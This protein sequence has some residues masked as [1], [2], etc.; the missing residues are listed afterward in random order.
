ML[1]IKNV[2]TPQGSFTDLT[3]NGTATQSLDAEKKLIVFPAFVDP[4]VQLSSF[5]VK[6]KEQ[7]KSQA[8]AILQA[9][10]S[11]VFDSQGIA[12][13]EA[14]VHKKTVEDAL[15][16]AN[17]PLSIHFFCDG[18]NAAD[19]D[20][21]GKNK[22]SFIG[23]KTTIDLAK[24]PL[25][26]LSPSVL[27][28]LFQIAAQ[29]DLIVVMAL[30]QGKGDAHEQR[31]NALATVRKSVALAEKYSAQLC[32]QHVRTKEELEVIKEAKKR[33]I[34]VFT[35]VAYPHLFMTENDIPPDVLKAS[36]L[37]LPTP[38]DREALWAAI[39]NGSIDMVGSGSQFSTPEDPIFAARMFFPSMIN[40]YRE[41]KLS[42]GALEA[43]TRVNAQNI[44]R[45][46]PNDDVILVDMNVTKPLAPAYMQKGSLLSYWAE[47][48]F[49]GW[50]THVI[51]R[52]E[53]VSTQ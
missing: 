13:D 24:V 50:P 44:F 31:K 27:D 36:R 33:G 53:L 37:F 4:D 47:R 39:A 8:K 38:D 7:W 9:G 52:G 32:L 3:F 6:S 48:T 30:M 28:R 43:V 45:L 51:A 15:A 17:I 26:P 22:H 10:I 34:L 29:E 21:I 1:T 5:Q 12:P 11:C 19:F 41:R 49:T 46:P 40:A 16:Q 14:R 42:L 2:Q 25:P 18:R 35:E 23:I 20:N